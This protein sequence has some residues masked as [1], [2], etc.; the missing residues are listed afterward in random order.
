[1]KINRHSTFRAALVQLA[2][3]ETAS[4]G[5]LRGWKHTA[6]IVRLCCTCLASIQDGI[7]WAL[8]VE[9]HARGSLRAYL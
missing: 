5:T 6:T 7:G 2:T 4:A 8:K 3:P 1:M 9:A